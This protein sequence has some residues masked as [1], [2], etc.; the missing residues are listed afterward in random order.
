MV[1]VKVKHQEEEILL[2]HGECLQ[3]REGLLA[4]RA[5]V[6]V[7]HATHP[8]ERWF[9]RAAPPLVLWCIVRGFVPDP[10][11]KPEVLHVDG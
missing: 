4:A 8:S 5:H 7:A 1:V 2:H 3:R 10:A 9:Q 11:H 6:L